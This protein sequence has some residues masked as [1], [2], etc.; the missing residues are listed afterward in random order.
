M[1][2]A[3]VGAE[4]Y[5]R[6]LNPDTKQGIVD[7]Q[8]EMDKEYF[9]EIEKCLRNN[10]GL[11][12]AKGTVFVVVICKKE[13]LMENVVRRYF[14]CRQTL[15]TPDYDQTVWLYRKG[16]DL[17]FIWVT[18][19]HNTCEEIYF[20]KHQMPE[21]E[22]WLYNLVRAFME[23]RLYKEAVENFNIPSRLLDN[24]DMCPNHVRIATDSAEKAPV[25][26]S[27]NGA[28]RPLIFT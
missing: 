6:L 21:N 23:G 7:T 12:D 9:E 4:A 27:E 14:I 18:P 3:T 15:P 28:S 5:K 22:R 25:Q 10:K 24:S 11:V 16:Q 17:Q 1:R 2:T 8:R 13:R 19:D 20:G 26:S